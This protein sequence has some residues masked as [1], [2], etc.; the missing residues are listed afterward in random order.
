MEIELDLYLLMKNVELKVVLMITLDSNQLIQL[1]QVEQ[2]SIAH[3]LVDS[4]IVPH[5]EIVLSY[6]ARVRS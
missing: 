4:L 6:D 3:H 5:W 1:V 2:E